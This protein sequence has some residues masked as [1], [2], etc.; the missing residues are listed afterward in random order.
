MGGRVTPICVTKNVHIHAGMAGSAMCLAIR[1]HVHEQKETFCSEKGVGNY[2]RPLTVP[3]FCRHCPTCSN[4][5]FL[6]GTRV[7]C[8][9]SYQC[10]PCVLLSTFSCVS[11]CEGV[12]GGSTVVCYFCAQEVVFSLDSF[13]PLLLLLLLLPAFVELVCMV[14][15]VWLVVEGMAEKGRHSSSQSWPS[16]AAY[17]VRR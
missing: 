16:D 5:P 6:V 7:P 15:K 11:L 17:K 12:G 13:Q 1:D 8:I 4:S 2:G 9:V 10:S 14:G 3:P